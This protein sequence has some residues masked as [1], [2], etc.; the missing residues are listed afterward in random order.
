M[1]D[2]VLLIGLDG[3]R[4]D[5][6]KSF[7]EQGLIP[8][9]SDFLESGVSGNLQ[10]VYPIHS[11]P[12][13]TSLSTGQYPLNHGVY[14]SSIRD[15]RESYEMKYANSGDVSSER[16]WEAFSR[17]G[18]K[19]GVFGV[20]LTFPPDVVDGVL[21]SG[22]LT[23]SKKVNY[24][25]PDHIKEVT[26]DI[27]YKFAPEVPAGNREGYLDEVYKTTKSKVTLVEWFMDH[28]DWD[29]CFP[30]FIGTEQLHHHFA[31][32]LD[33]D[34]PHYKKEFEGIIKRFYGK[35]DEWI[36]HLIKKA[37]PETNVFIVSDHGF[38]PVKS[39]VDIN[40][41]LER[42]GYLTIDTKEGENTQPLRGRIRN[43]LDEGGIFFKVAKIVY[44]RLPP[45]LQIKFKDKM[46]KPTYPFPVDWSE[47]EAYSLGGECI[48]LNLK[49]REPSGTVTKREYRQKL[50]KIIDDL[51]QDDELSPY[52]DEIFTREIYGA[53]SEE[54]GPDLFLKPGGV[55]IISKGLNR[56]NPIR[57]S[58]TLEPPGFHIGRHTLNG[59]FL[60][61]GPSIE[62]KKHL[63]RLGIV[64]V[65]PTVTHL[66]DLPVSD[67]YDGKVVKAV[68]AEDSEPLKREVKQETPPEEKRESQEVD[69]ELV[70]DRLRAFGYIE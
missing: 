59:V 62:E 42:H 36:G 37:G 43:L 61:K 15:S 2:K 12:A 70:E 14:G 50:K 5:V 30:V 67:V 41:F 38:G 7:A 4:L 3:A 33:P 22:W 23:P 16:L 35:V 47:T 60:G 40:V 19:V 28:Y 46:R 29:F 65:A 26:E 64:D 56:D 27:G 63:G 52:L 51:M 34:H 9:I 10:S 24:T 20:P 21:V 32:F 69:Q 49:G 57:G 68:F 1:A 25:Y 13:W 58:K 18:K 53:S 17:Y 48:N 31:S 11:I 55:H 45:S 39:Q 66:A 6:L 8:N 54:I 44:D